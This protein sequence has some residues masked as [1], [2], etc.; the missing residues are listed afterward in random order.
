[1]ADRMAHDAASA[2]RRAGSRG[3]SLQ[4]RVYRVLEEQLRGSAFASGE[5]LPSE[6]ALASRFAVSRVTIRAALARLEQD[7]RICRIQGRGTVV[8]APPAPVLPRL[9]LTDVLSDMEHVA[10]TTSVQVVAF[11]YRPAPP[12]VAAM[13]SLAAGATCQ[14]AV[15]LRSAGGQVILQVTTWFPEATGHL[16][17]ASDLAG[18]P[19]QAMRTRHGLVPR[20]GQQ[21]VTATIA[22]PDVAKRLGVPLGAPLLRVQRSY[23]GDDNIPT[24]YCDA[25]G[26]ASSFELRMAL[27]LPD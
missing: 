11:D 15:R 14:Y 21:V 23:V 12:D 1:M 22:G 8:A 27:R 16:W 20:G 24:E 10:R 25:L 2:R 5:V 3:V 9:S 13:L 7:G 18:G 17:T 26:P 19:L 4:E 6:E